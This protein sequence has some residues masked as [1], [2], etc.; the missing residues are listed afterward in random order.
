MGANAGSLYA[1]QGE[2]KISDNTVYIQTDNWEFI[3]NL[4]LKF[5]LK[6]LSFGTGQPLIKSSEIK[7]LN[8]WTPDNNSEQQIIG[9]FLSTIKSL[10]ALHQR[11]LHILEK[12]KSLYVYTAF[13][14]QGQYEPKLRFKNYDEEWQRYKL[15][16]LADIISG[17]TPSTKNPNFWDGDIDWYSPA[18]IG[19][20]I[21]V[22]HSKKRIT[23][24]GLQK[25]NAKLLPVNTVLFTSR[26]GIGNTAILAKVGATN[27][28][29]QSIIP[30][31]A[32]LDSYFL[33]TRTAEL[34]RY[35][36][37]N[38]AGSTFVEV[39]GKQMSKMPIIVPKID[40]QIEISKMFKNIDNILALHHGKLE[41]L[42]KIKKVYLNK[43]FI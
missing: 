19:N 7:K 16:D 25:S 8:M 21:Y 24:L 15:G 6:K 38:G 43:M 27:Q 28:G 33:F 9:D 12:I 3:Y 4:L 10:I 1:F 32:L 42:K 29:F 39:S 22:E 20:Q 40:E 36:E 5:N 35:G 11:K 34:K 14:K 37:V 13:P 41:Q 31:K 18:E 26:A 17:G 2:V 23:K 30:K